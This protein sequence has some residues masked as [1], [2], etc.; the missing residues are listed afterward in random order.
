MKWKLFSNRRKERRGAGQILAVSV[1]VLTLAAA[2]TTTY[3]LNANKMETVTVQPA[4]I[5]SDI[6]DQE[7]AVAPLP[8]EQP[9]E[10]AVE[11]EA[12]EIEAAPDAEPVT[13]TPVEPSAAEEPQQAEAVVTEPAPV[14][15]T[16][17]QEAPAEEDAPDAID[18]ALLDEENSFGDMAA[19]K[20]TESP[21]SEETE[22]LAAEDPLAERYELLEQARAAQPDEAGEI[23][24]TPD[25]LD[26]L[27]AAE[28]QSADIDEENCLSWLI[29][30]LFGSNTSSKKY[31]GWRTSGGKTYYY[32]PDTHEALTGLQT[33]DGKIY[34]FDSNGV[35]Q[36]NVTLGVDVSKY[37][38]DI[39]WKKVKAAGAEFA[40]VRIGYRG[41][42]SGTLVL[43]SM[44]ESHLAGA[45]AAGLDVGVYIFSQAI[46]EEE[47]IEE[48]FACYYVL[49][50]RALE[51]PVYFDSEY[52]TSSH[53][54]RADG[55]S[56]AERTACAVAFCEEIQKY[57]YDAGV[58]A[59]TTW[60][61]SKLDL[62]ALRSYSIW[63]AHYGVAKSSIDCDMWQGSCTGTVNGY[64]GQ[65]DLDI[66]YRR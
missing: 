33:I 27:L 45:Q 41:Y 19:D 43:D 20:H 60:F 7:S 35:Q 23:L 59:S 66:S 38:S 64:S 22:A 6:V 47:A 58:Y 50:G 63:N 30:L 4:V 65:L 61:N 14:A 56:K 62:S 34:Y 44:F 29:N 10:A 51:Y 25:Q 57:G 13:Q 24:L 5:R 32:D 55:L 37:Q 9:E 1:V 46:N 52:A 12:P 26:A 28:N 36:E 31:S 16:V 40:I 17:P 3:T 8:A 49:D 48:A 21:W 39:N 15:A 42:G 18:P 11:Q 2:G 53:N 54:G